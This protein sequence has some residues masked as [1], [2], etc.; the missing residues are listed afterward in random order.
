VSAG[1]S[2][3]PV[4]G[5]A[6]G[7][8]AGDPF[9]AVVAGV[10][11]ALLIG[12]AALSH[13]ERQ[14]LSAPI[15]YL[16]VGVA[17]SVFLGLLGLPRLDPI[18]DALLVE[19]VAEFA[20]VIALFATGLRIHP[21]LEWHR[22]RPA[23]LLLGVG[24]PLTVLAGAA[25]GSAL[26]GLPVG[27]AIILAAALAPTDPVLAGD[28]GVA[29][30]DE[31]ET[32]D[33]G[34]THGRFALTG[35]AGLNDGLAYPFL[36]LGAL[37]MSRD[38]A[39]WVVNWVLTDVVYAIVVAGLAGA[40]AG[41]ALAAALLPLHE[42]GLLASGAEHFLAAAAAIGIY[43]AVQVA[44]AYGFVAVFVAGVAFRR[45]EQGHE[46]NRQLHDGASLLM[47]F[48]ELIVVVLLGSMVTLDGLA[49]PG[50]G[51]WLLALAIIVVVRPVVALACVV[52]S[53]M[54]RGERALVSWFGVRGVATLYYAAVAVGGGALGGDTQV[55]V[56]T[57]LATV[58]LSVVIHSVTAIPV[59]R[60]HGTASDAR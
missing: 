47:R 37:A 5:A 39:G 57:A 44:D 29:P 22:W 40:V 8:D 35:E 24:L 32:A 54:P 14:G 33:R 17:A 11:L 9:S 6:P 1:G 28:I 7:L 45:Y 4:L 55:V 41:Y 13:E 16:A 27:V 48:G 31:E 42:R 59:N 2:A 23:V 12:V 36:L 25:L 60:R 58:A 21:R 26:L 38:G 46:Y 34:L 43:G 18:E 51:G 56:W 50:L 53:D 15:V 52:G 49:A 10:G 19:R 3:V 30:P 20:L